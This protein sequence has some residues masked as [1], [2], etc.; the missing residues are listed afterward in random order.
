MTVTNVPKIIRNISHVE[1]VNIN[2]YSRLQN[3]RMLN[4]WLN[5]K[6]NS[7][8]KRIKNRGMSCNRLCIPTFV[9]KFEA[10]KF[11]RFVR[12]TFHVNR[13]TRIRQERVCRAKSKYDLMRI[14]SEFVFIP[15]MQESIGC[16]M[17]FSDF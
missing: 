15:E 11:S 17:T 12:F 13:C 1:L 9:I 10:R 14:L 6:N 8:R 16:C 4:I 5:I 7:S 3:A 2:A